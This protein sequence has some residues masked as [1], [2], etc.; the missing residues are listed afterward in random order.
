MRPNHPSSTPLT[1]RRKSMNKILLVII[2]ALFPVS[3]SGQI[4]T[5]ISANIASTA[6]D[7][8]DFG[9]G[10]NLSAGYALSERLELEIQAQRY[11]L[12]AIT[13]NNINSLSIHARFSPFT[14]NYL[15]PYI[16]FGAGL[17]RLTGDPITISDNGQTT[18]DI[19]YDLRLFKPKLG[20]IM[21]SG[22]HP[23][24]FIDVGIFYERLIYR[25]VDNRINWYGITGGLK[26]IIT[27]N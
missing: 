1:L 4:V 6:D 26:W 27:H 5:G 16:D 9:T 14:G 15:R 17:A 21:P 11:W 2:A 10:I 25:D 22:F 19:D 18:I 3:L 7:A 20:M 24:F 12:R 23:D 8:I 13:L